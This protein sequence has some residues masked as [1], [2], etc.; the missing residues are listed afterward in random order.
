[1]YRLY[2]LENL[3]SNVLR[4]DSAVWSVPLHVAKSVW[5]TFV[6]TNVRFIITLCQISICFRVQRYYK[7]CTYARKASIFF[8]KDIFYLSVI[9]SYCSAEVYSQMNS[10]IV[11]QKV[12]TDFWK[13]ASVL[14]YLPHFAN[15]LSRWDCPKAMSVSSKV[16]FLFDIR[17]FTS[18]FFEKHHYPIALVASHS[19]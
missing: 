10:R 8:K 19:P 17:K 3:L 6:L 2:V 12:Q 16:L 18:T 15:V 1:M 4:A 11:L 14:A 7:K 5:T 13:N 9:Q